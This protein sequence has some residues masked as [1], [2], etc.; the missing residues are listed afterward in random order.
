MYLYELPTT[1]AI[2]FADVCSD[3]SQERGYTHHIPEATQA[4]ANLRG[5]LKESKRAEHGEKDFLSLVK[6]I[7]EYLPHI[8]SLIDCVAHDEIGIKTEPTFSWRT[9]LSASRFNT[10]PRLDLPGLH[11]DYAFT[12]LTYGFALSNLAH[13]IVTS[14]GIYEHDRAISDVDRKSKDE[15]LNVAVDFLCRASGIFSFISDTVL[16]DWETSRASPP[17]FHKPPDLTR[18]I[19]HALAKMALA[20]AQTLAIRRLLSKSAY[21]SNITPGPPLPKS[22]PPPALLAK[23]HIECAGLYSS[24]RLLAKTPGSTQSSSKESSKDVSSDLRRYLNNQASLH[25]ALSHKW[26]GVE[27]GEKAGTDAGGTEKGGEAVAFLQW[28]K[29]ELEEVKD[30]GK[31]VSLGSSDKEKEEEW[32][33]RINDELASVN[34]FFKYYKKMN[35]TLH[36]Q[37]VPPQRSLQSRIPGGRIAIPAKPYIP[38]LPAF[39]PGSLEYTRRKAEQLDMDGT[40]S[41]D[42]RG[43]LGPAASNAA[44]TYAGAG[45]YFWFVRCNHVFV[46]VLMICPLLDLV[47]IMASLE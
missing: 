25:S 4:R 28:A 37:P 23:L 7:E 39:G 29:K 42:D 27:A 44:G 40:T 16:P 32:K 3:H 47:H 26:L 30:G 14:V 18:E 43:G 20:D 15:K 19:N 8:R 10:S 6:L 45:S 2:S 21:D 46:L 1:G 24:A 41:T 31:L 13:T 17:G 5:V 22:H 12:L 34:V 11:A 36:F 35:D 33:A 38:P 9:T